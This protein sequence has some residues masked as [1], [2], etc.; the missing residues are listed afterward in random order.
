MS[1]AALPDLQQTAAPPKPHVLRVNDLELYTLTALLMFAPLAFGA[2]EAWAIFVL[3]LGACILFCGWMLRQLRA[4]RL[5]IRRN[6]VFFPMGAFGA[7]AI[8]QLAPGISAYRHATYSTFLLYTVYGLMCFLLT[9]VLE[10]TSNLRRL[11]LGFTVYGSA[12]AAFAVLQSLSSNGKLYWVRTPRFGGWI[13][14]PY[15]NHNHYAGL[16]EMLAPVPMVYAFS[17][18]AHGWKKWLAAAAA[19]FMGASIFLSGSRGGMTAF[20]LELAVFF[21]FLFRERTRNRI[22]MLLGAF[23]L[24]TLASIVWIGGSEVSTR[25]SSLAD[26]KHPDLNADIRLKIDRDALHMIAQRP[27]LGWGLGT[28]ADVYPQFRSFYTNSL[29]NQAHND[30]LQTMI[31]TGILGFAVAVWLLVAVIRPALRKIRNWPSDVN[32][33]MTLA[34]LLGI[35]GILVHSLF[36]FNLEI[37]ANAMLFY[38]LCTVAA[39]EPRF[40]NLRREYKRHDAGA[41]EMNAAMQSDAHA[42]AE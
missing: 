26:Y 30:Y 15:V 7:L 17:R 10:R 12:L 16:M 23:L 6:P 21:Y 31:E 14:G 36:D 39:M 9:Q 22:A 38:A 24:V 5:M 34:A 11:G 32:G 8:V 4:E 25:I 42:F 18:Y 28:F 35:S 13:Y 37:P 1:A 27:L 20:A 29:V 3:Q 40:R 2:V 19:A 41:S 33:I